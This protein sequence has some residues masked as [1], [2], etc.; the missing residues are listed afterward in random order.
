[1]DRRLTYI[2]AMPESRPPIELQGLSLAEL[3]ALMAVGRLRLF[4]HRDP[5]PG[6]HSEMRIARARTWYPQAEPIRRPA[7][8]GLF[9]TVLRREPDGR[10]MLITPVEKVEID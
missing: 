2:A 9:S 6:G 8:V 10:H 1:M 7:T 5:E 4:D 3:Q